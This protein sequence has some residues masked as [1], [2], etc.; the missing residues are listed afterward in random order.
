M[1]RRLLE[2]C[3]GIVLLLGVFILSGEA[4]QVMNS[5]DSASELIVID[6]GHGGIDPGM[7]GNDDTLEKDINLSICLKLKACLEEE[8]YRVLLTRDDDSGLYDENASG[9][10]VQDLQRRCNLI[11]ENEPALTVSIHQN[12]YADS[13][14]KGPQVFYYANSKNGELLASSVQE[15]LNT[16][17]EVERPRL[18]KSNTSY[19][20]L[21]KSKGVLI[22]AE[23]GFLTNPDEIEKLK[24]EEYQQK[25]AQAICDGIKIYLD[26]NESG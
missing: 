7:V 11:A 5:Q 13:S 24:Q 25:V 1:K 12:S 17:L 3:M 21:K 8:G 19:Y 10:K 22:I 4:V 18:P 23:C 2:L 9:K 14:A 26:G 20:L 15:Q 16:Q 6:P